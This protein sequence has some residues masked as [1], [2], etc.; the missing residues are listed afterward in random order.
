MSRNVGED[1]P[2][3]WYPCADR[4]FTFNFPRGLSDVTNFGQTARHAGFEE[5]AALNS[6]LGTAI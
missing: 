3:Y 4:S 2:E 6:H 5:D 1:S